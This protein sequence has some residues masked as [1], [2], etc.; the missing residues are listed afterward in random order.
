[1]RGEYI[2][3]IFIFLHQLGS[4]PLAWGIPVSSWLERRKHGI[5]PT[6]VGNTIRA[7]PGSS[8]C[9]DHPH[10]RGEY[11]ERQR[12]QLWTMGS[13]PL[14]WGIHENEVRIKSQHGITPTCVGNTMAQV[15]SSRANQDHPHLRG[16]YYDSEGISQRDAGSPPL[17]WG[18][19]F[20]NSTISRD[21]RITPTCVGNTAKS[22]CFGWTGR[23][24]PHL[25]GEYPF[26]AV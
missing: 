7:R 26:P 14:A 22:G 20:Y 23:D 1:M 12:R 21:D 8:S 4:P 24:H 9:R 3:V 2:F 17:A 16:E 18:I 25:R 5:T 19:Q 13:P 6:C 15:A 11:R 10:L